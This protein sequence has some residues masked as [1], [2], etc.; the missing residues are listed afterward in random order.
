MN[1]NYLS[2]GRGLQSRGERF[3]DAL[4][5]EV[6]RYG[7]GSIMLCDAISL[8]YRSRP[9]V[10]PGELIEVRC[11]DVLDLPLVF[12]LSVAI[13]LLTLFQKD[14]VRCHTTR[15][16]T[17]CRPRTNVLHRALKSAGLS[18]TGYVLDISSSI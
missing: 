13:R 15:V 10:V 18:P 1:A 12:H 3:A 11:Q 9:V 5:C 2:R 14:N 16:C 7:G 6:D 17:A 4:V 8:D